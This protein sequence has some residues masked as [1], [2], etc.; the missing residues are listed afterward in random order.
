MGWYS[1]CAVANRFGNR[2][3]RL[4]VN[5][6]ASGD[7]I[8]E[9]FTGQNASDTRSHTRSLIDAVTEIMAFGNGGNATIFFEVRTIGADFG[10]ELVESLR[11]VQEA[12]RLLAIAV[13]VVSN[14]V[15]RWWTTIGKMFVV[16]LN[17]V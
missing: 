16:C 11:I 3:P 6:S 15:M 2:R 8:R 13:A 14:P 10:S 9:D 17:T 5:I 12:E 4:G 7:P 1:R